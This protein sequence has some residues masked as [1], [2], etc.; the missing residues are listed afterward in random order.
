MLSFLADLKSLVRGAEFESPWVQSP[1]EIFLLPFFLYLFYLTEKF[2]KYHMQQRKKKD[3]INECLLLV[4]LLSLQSILKYCS[5]QSFVDVSLMSL[6][7]FRLCLCL[8]LKPF[9]LS[10]SASSSRRF[11]Y[12]LFLTI[13]WLP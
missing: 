9:L 4:V 5:H 1:K 6:N 8:H 10:S 2:T 7:N 13:Q 3:G 12:A 11:F